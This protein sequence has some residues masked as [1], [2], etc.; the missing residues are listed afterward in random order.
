MTTSLIVGDCRAH[1]PALPDRRFRCC[2]TSP[3]YL[4]QRHYLPNDHPDAA[5]EIGREPTIA[6]YIEGLVALFRIV[7]EKLT[8]D[9]TLWLNLGDTYSAGGKGGGGSL[10][11]LREKTGWRGK[12]TS[13]G[14]RP[15]P[16]GLAEKQLL[17]IPW[18]VALALQDDGWWLRSEIV[19]E[20]PNALPSSV[21]DRP[22]TAHEHVF[23]LA[24]SE[25]YFFNMAAVREPYAT[26]ERA[27]RPISDKAFRGQRAMKKGG[28]ST[29]HDYD[30]GGRNM[31]SVWRIATERSGTE[32]T[33]P[34]PRALARRCL[35][36]GSAPGDHVL[37]PFG[38]S[39]TLGV[40]AEEDGRHATLIDLDERACAQAGRRTAQMG[41]LHPTG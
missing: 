14:W 2:I 8:D 5:R 27:G 34:M 28:E 37:D 31:R 15:P 36:A 33:A 30:K 32:H 4:W 10:M 40:V 6:A 35:L 21:T 11:K 19:W 41:L 26:P 24:K 16:A 12:N 3:P 18:R 38:G 9:G 13:Y 23:L 7:R 17:G 25:I 20:K 29:A 1:L 22:T 39:G